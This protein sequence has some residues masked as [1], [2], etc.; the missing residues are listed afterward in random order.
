[1]RIISG[2]HKGRKIIAPKNLSAR[3]T[4]DVAKEGLFNILTHRIDIADTS[5]LDLFSGTGN[6]SFE[7]CSR[8]ARMVTAVEQDRSACA[9]IR[10]TAEVLDL[11]AL[12]IRCAKVETFLQSLPSP[13]DLVFMDPPYQIG[14]QGYS[15]IIDL[16]LHRGWLNEDGL[17]VAEHFSKVEL[18]GLE[19]YQETRSYG[20]NSF[21][22]FKNKSRS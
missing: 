18:S 17:L 13:F 2:L 3:P 9:F 11:K 21:S 22:F 6:I 12:D 5:V 19:F 10:K 14:I 15:T 7:F 4:T 20:S 8:G 16:I 1:M